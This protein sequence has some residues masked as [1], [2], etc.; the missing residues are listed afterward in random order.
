ME[1]EDGAELVLSPR[2]LNNV[3]LKSLKG[4]KDNEQS[5]IFTQSGTSR[6][7]TLDSKTGTPPRCHRQN[8]FHSLSM[9]SKCLQLSI[10]WHTNLYCTALHFTALF[11]HNIRG[12]FLGGD[13]KGGHCGHEKVRPLPSPSA[14]WRLH[15]AVMTTSYN[16]NHYL[17]YL[18]S[19]RTE[20]SKQYWNL[21]FNFLPDLILD[22]ISSL[23]PTPSPPRPL[24]SNRG[25][26]LPKRDRLVLLCKLGHGASGVV[27]KVRHCYPSPLLSYPLPYSTLLYSTQPTMHL[28]MKSNVW[29]WEYGMADCAIIWC[30]RFHST[31]VRAPY[32][33]HVLSVLTG[34]RLDRHAARCAEN[35]FSIRTVSSLNSMRRITLYCLWTHTNTLSL[36]V[37]TTPSTIPSLLSSRSAWSCI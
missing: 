20:D 28:Y 11:R 18:F 35:D 4:N 3:P 13:W 31:C 15:E 6:S 22:P 12:R 1:D 25:P 14:T 29:Y 8:T 37:D 19:R 9:T 2:A 23:S 17:T 32:L 27:Y 36:L 7:W 10:I 24:S 30:K 26:K 21:T 33:L 16:Q 34:A 5:Y